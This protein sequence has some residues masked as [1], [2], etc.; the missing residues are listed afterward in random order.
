[1]ISFCQNN[2]KNTCNINNLTII[3]LL[4][5]FTHFMKFLNRSKFLLSVRFKGF[6]Y[7]ISV[8]KSDTYLQNRHICSIAS[9][10]DN[11]II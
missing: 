9:I 2:S 4:F 3:L 8:L 5:I 1:M 10:N 11:I 7:D 6:F